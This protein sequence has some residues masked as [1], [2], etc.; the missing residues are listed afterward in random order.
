M[1]VPFRNRLA[2]SMIE[3]L[4]VLGLL[5]FLFA[6]FIPAVQRVRAAAARTQSMNNLLQQGIAIHSFHDIHRKLPFNGVEGAK[7]DPKKPD[8]GSWA[9]RVLS[10]VEQDPLFQNPQN[11]LEVN[12]PVYLCPTRSRPGFTSEGKFK[13]P[14]TDYALNTWINDPKNGALGA[15]NN[16]STLAA[17]P[18]GTSNTILVGQLSLKTT[19]YQARDAAPG[20]ESILF[21]GTSG[22]GRNAFKHVQDGPD[23]DSSNR[24]GGPYRE[25]TLIMMGDA[26]TRI[27][28]YRR[29]LETALKPNDGKF[30]PL[31]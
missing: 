12:L 10:F 16:N 13:G 31:D 7:A 2:V 3:V 26:S 18:D 6:L 14:I 11:A 9:Y 27:V 8:S 23:I 20:R 25:G 4:I 28:P 19:E 5:A 30:D 22:T 24:F 29:D 17:I 21:G 1:R 15:P